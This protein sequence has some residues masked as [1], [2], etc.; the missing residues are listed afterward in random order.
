MQQ[1]KREECE[2]RDSPVSGDGCLYIDAKFTS[3]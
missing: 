1:D 2:I 3:S